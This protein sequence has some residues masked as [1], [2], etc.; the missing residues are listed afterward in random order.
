MDWRFNIKNQGRKF[1]LTIALNFGGYGGCQAKDFI[2]VAK[3]AFVKIS[4]FTEF[5]FDYEP[6]AQYALNDFKAWLVERE[7]KQRSRIH[8][9]AQKRLSDYFLLTAKEN[10][11]N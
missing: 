5:E 6:Q 9:A 11:I 2:P 7:E 4:P 10:V 1:I 3:T 8:A